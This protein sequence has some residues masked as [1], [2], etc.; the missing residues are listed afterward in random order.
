MVIHSDFKALHG[1]ILH[2]SL[3]PS[4]DSM[5]SESLDEGICPKSQIGQGILVTS[6]TS[7]LTIPSRSSSNNRTNLT[8]RFP[9][10]NVDTVS[11]R[12]TGRLTILRS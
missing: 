1:I 8:Q 6:Y 5:I 2:C 11:R 3:L 4:I 10:M 9:W 12:V 7:I